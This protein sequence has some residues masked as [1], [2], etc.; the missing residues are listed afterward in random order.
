MN[1]QLSRLAALPLVHGLRPAVDWAA[2]TEAGFDALVAHTRLLAVRR[3]EAT[4][5]S[6]SGGV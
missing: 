1:E 4:V 5:L 2:L 6:E 3:A